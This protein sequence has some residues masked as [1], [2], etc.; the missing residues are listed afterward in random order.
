MLAAARRAYEEGDFSTAIVYLFSHQLIELDRHQCIRLAKGKTN[1]QYL[2]ELAQR[3]D[4]RMLL[5]ET[6]VRFERVFFGDQRLDQ[7]AFED[8]WRQL[9][10]FQQLVA[11][12]TR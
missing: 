1:R 3:A 2:R 9:P 8:C 6:M 11:G 4:L 5:S 7:A 12:A 10:Q